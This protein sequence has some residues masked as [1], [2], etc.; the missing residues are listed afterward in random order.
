MNLKFD[1]TLILKS[2][3]KFGRC[4]AFINIDKFASVY[5]DIENLSPRFTTQNWGVDL[6]HGFIPGIIQVQHNSN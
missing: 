4:I 6:K 5:V 2:Y 1:I 3:G